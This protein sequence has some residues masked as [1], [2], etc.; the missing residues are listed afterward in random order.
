[1]LRAHRFSSS[2]VVVM[3]VVVGMHGRERA[4]M[5]LNHRVE[6]EDHKEREEDAAHNDSG[7]GEGTPQREVK[8]CGAAA[9]WSRGRVGVVAVE[10]GEGD[11]GGAD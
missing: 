9:L 7:G 3:V 2:S 6:K 8:A 10:R 1:M 4:G 11:E 5:A